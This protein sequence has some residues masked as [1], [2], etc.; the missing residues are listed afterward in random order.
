[1]AL[2]R[3]EAKMQS[4]LGYIQANRAKYGRRAIVE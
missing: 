2:A 4:N 1:M 3:P